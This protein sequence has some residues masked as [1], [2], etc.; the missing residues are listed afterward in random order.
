MA[1]VLVAEDDKY[2]A[3]AYRVKLTKAGYELKIAS[4][5]QEALE[6]LKTFTPDV[7][8]LDLIMPV[9]DG[10]SV[11]EEI[12]KNPSLKNIPIII[13]SNLSQKED[14]DR[15]IALGAS[16]YIIKSQMPI[17]VV[18]AKIQKHLESKPQE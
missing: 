8:L 6:I 7:M 13:T 16:D 17:S 1:K 18:L 10:F 12:K 15:G 3:S 11:L 5:G 4:D 9:R 14:I 2:L